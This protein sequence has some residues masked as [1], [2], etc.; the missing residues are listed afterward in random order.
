MSNLLV[1]GQQ[2]NIG[3]ELTPS[4]GRTVLV[5]QADGNL[6]LYRVDDSTVLWASNTRGQPVTCAIMQGDGNFVCYD[7]NGRAH[8]ATRTAGNPGSYLLVQDDGNLVVYTDNGVALWA[9]NTVQA[10]PPMSAIENVS[11][12]R[13]QSS[14]AVYLIVGDTKFRIENEAEFGTLGFDWAKV[15]TVVDGSLNGF[16][17]RLLH[18]PPAVRPSDVFFDCGDVENQPP[19]FGKF[20]GNCKPSASIVSKDILV[21]G[22]LWTDESYPFVNWVAKGTKDAQGHTVNPGV[23]D[24]HYNLTLDAVF[25][26]K[27]YGP[28]GLSRWL[29]YSHWPG[30]PPAA[31][32]IPFA[33]DPGGPGRP[34]AVTFNSWI[35]PTNEMDVH[36]EL[37][38]WHVHD[39]NPCGVFPL[40]PHGFFSVHWRGRG[41]QPA[42]WIIP[43]WQ[44]YPDWQNVDDYD[45]WFPFDPLDPEGLG[46]PLRK[47]MYILMRGTIWQEDNHGSLTPGWSSPPTVGY[48]GGT[49]MHPPDWIVRV[50]EPHANARLTTWR[51]APASPDVTG[52]QITVD[53]TIRPDFAPSATGLLR[54]RRCQRLVDPRFTYD[55]SVVCVRE[56]V[57]ADHVDVQVVVQPT[58]T[59]QARFKGA[60]LV[61]WSELD[62]A[63]QVWVDDQTPAGATLL[64]D[65][66]TWDWETDNVF[67]GSRAHRSALKAG[68]HQHYFYRA[69]TPLVSEATD[70]LFATVFLDPDNPPDEVML[71]WHTT[72]WLSR[73][74]WGANLINWGTDGTSQRRHIGPLP[75]SGEWVRL[76]VLAQDVGIDATTPIDGMAFTLH[77]GHVTWDYAGVNKAS[78]YQ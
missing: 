11:L 48:D 56:Q 40:P 13:E 29:K 64:A 22:W 24:I 15:R 1:A 59:E 71:Q 43:D 26:D 2:L 75:P 49:E 31:V 54:V 76:T 62:E 14:P 18:A 60:W 19:C 34:P 37:N 74:Y 61:G 21:A 45:A 65:N 23:E 73:A 25:L 33:T 6:V 39:T 51:T 72:D 20:Y 4:T 28:D 8:W 32:Q 12:V 57:S 17:E 46:W 35:L 58:G 78:I 52:P 70:I 7:A 63:D 47:G 77:G 38:A 69:A 50:R 30:N 67:S 27:M 10:W 55:A 9:S 68:M 16:T 5:M 53:N 36:G 44:K 66:E 42:G 41:Q 3:D